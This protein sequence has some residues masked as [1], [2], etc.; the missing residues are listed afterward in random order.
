LK[1]KERLLSFEEPTRFIFSHSALREGW[2]NP[3]VFVIGTL[4][5]SDSTISRCQEVGRG[6]RLAVTQTGDRL[7]DPATVHHYNVLTVVANE[8]YQ[9]FVAGLQKDISESLSER[10]RVADAA[11][12]NGKVLHTPAGD[13]PVPP[14]MAKQIYRYLVKNDYTDDHDRIAEAYHQAKRDDQLAPLPDELKPYSEQVFRLIDSVF[15]ETDLPK[16]DNDRALK[17]NP[18][19]ANF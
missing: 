9:D 13:V 8:S 4:K 7:D 14:P 6:M 10:P 16:I 19:N 17:T 5:H 18:L 12:F 15:S 2:D 3:N 1:D 11:Y